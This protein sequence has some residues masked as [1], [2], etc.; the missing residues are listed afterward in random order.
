MIWQIL[1]F[2]T[3]LYVIVICTTVFVAVMYA[4]TRYYS[5]TRELDVDDPIATVLRLRVL[6]PARWIIRLLA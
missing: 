4:A 3:F 1:G 5:G 2:L 6:A